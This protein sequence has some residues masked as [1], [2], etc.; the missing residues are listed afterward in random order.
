MAWADYMTW[1]TPIRPLCRLRGIVT[2]GK[3]SFTMSDLG[4]SWGMLTLPKKKQRHHRVVSFCPAGGDHFTQG[5]LGEKGGEWLAMGRSAMTSG[6]PYSGE[7]RVITD[8]VSGIPLQGEGPLHTPWHSSLGQFPSIVT[9]NPL[10]Q[11]YL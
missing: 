9:Q 4:Q 7:S 6:N 2:P 1:H 3:Q 5:H 8:T 10:L 11:Q